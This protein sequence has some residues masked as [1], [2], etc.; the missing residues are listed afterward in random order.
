MKKFEV[1]C[2]PGDGIGVEVVPEAMR[3]LE[4]VAKIHGGLMFSF[5]T[6]YWNCDYY[7][8]HGRMM[9]EDGLD[10]LSQYDSVFLGAIGDVT[11]VPDHISVWESILTI[12]REFEQALNIRPAKIIQGVHSPLVNPK[13]FDLIVVRENSEG[14]YSTVGGKMYRGKD[15]IAVQNNFF[16]RRA[17]SEAMHYAFDLAK[18]RK[19]HV[20]SATKSNGIY[21]S[22]P[23][24]DE[25]FQEVSTDYP[26]IQ[27]DSQHIDALVAFFVTDP[28]RFDVIVASNLFGDILTDL[29]AGIM[30]SVGIAPAA[31]INLNGKYPSMFEPVHGS[32]PDIAGK[33]IANPIGQIWTAKLMLDHFGETELGDLVM[34]AIEK[35]I[36][37]GRTTKDIG[38]TLSTKEVTVE[39]LSELNNY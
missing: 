8:Q 4:A 1:A 29:G 33:G 7:V 16:S 28:S 6:F 13:D 22:M 24:W 17:M 32:A 5:D 21:H 2:M 30:G 3:V 31:N 19:G 11:K 35:V 27:T 15:E 12:R 38:G 23:F 18:K 37:S 9:P 14:E 39:I 36:Q 34:D 26:H 20:T 25:V 10:R